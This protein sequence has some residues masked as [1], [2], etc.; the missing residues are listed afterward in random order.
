MEVDTPT[1]IIKD[2]RLDPNTGPSNPTNFLV[3]RCIQPNQHGGDL[4][5][6]NIAKII[7]SSDEVDRYPRSAGIAFNQAR[8][9]PL[10]EDAFGVLVRLSFLN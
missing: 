4:S 8:I 6:E 9:I 1:F 5:A 10:P 3:S 7:A 2:G